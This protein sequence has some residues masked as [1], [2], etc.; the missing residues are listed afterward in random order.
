MIA[1]TAECF[2]IV[3][4]HNHRSIRIHPDVRSANG[5]HRLLVGEA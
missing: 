4:A 1:L 2:R 5:Q 3:G